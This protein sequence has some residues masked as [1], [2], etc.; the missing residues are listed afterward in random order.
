MSRPFLLVQLSDLHIGAN[1]NGFDP[2]P[3]LKAVV[4]A[5][6]AL[7][8]RPGTVAAPPRTDRKSVV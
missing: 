4:K 6:G 3:H 8:N 7:P 1:E 2:V 5:V